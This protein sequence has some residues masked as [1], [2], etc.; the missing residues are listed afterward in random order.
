MTTWRLIFLMLVGAC[1]A[2][3]GT[4]WAESGAL[5]GLP[6]LNTT[7]VNGKTIPSYSSQSGLRLTVDTTWVGSRG[8]R[9][10]QVTLSSAKPATAD[11]QITVRFHAGIW[12]N[13]YRSI[14]ME[15]DLEMLTGASDVSATLLV[16]QY[17]NWDGYGWE[18]WIDGKEDEQLAFKNLG[19]SSSNGNSGQYAALVLQSE[20]VGVNRIER[21][22]SFLE[23]LPLKV[24]QLPDS[25]SQLPK[26]WI[27]YTNFDVVVATPNDL[28]QWSQVVPKQFAEMLRWVRAGGN[29]WVLDVGKGYEQLPQVESILGLKL[30]GSSLEQ[31]GWQFLPLHSQPRQGADMLVLLEGHGKIEPK[32]SISPTQ[33]IDFKSLE[34]AADSR[35]WF[36]ARAHGMGT[37][38]AFQK[39]FDKPS[40]KEDPANPSNSA[41]Q[42]VEFSMLSERLNW[43]WRHGNDPAYGNRNFNDLLI[44]DIG[45]APVFGF[46]L[47]IT[48]FVLAIGPVNY[49]LLKRRGRLPLML[50]TVPVAAVAATLLLFSYGI[51]TEGFSVCV[52]AR[53]ITLLDQ[54]NG[55]ATCWARLSYYAG[56]APSKGLKMPDDTVVYPIH[57]TGRRPAQYAWEQREVEWGEQQNMIR[58]WLASRT[59][60]QYLTITARPT[61]QQLVFEPKDDGLLVTNRLGVEV[62]MLVVQDHAGKFYMGGTL[63]TDDFARLEPTDMM[64]AMAR[65]RVLNTENIPEFPAGFAAPGIGGEA[66]RSSQL[67]EEHAFSTS[68]LEAQ[69]NAVVSPLVEDWGNGTYI[70]ITTTG[71]SLALGLEEVVES[72]SFHMV[73]GNWLPAA[74]TKEK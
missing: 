12:K 65:L 54:T 30:S 48:L 4:A 2:L 55:E 27:G 74:A 57:P 44:P 33:K 15:Q 42:A 29:L 58:G 73:H 36:V 52:R 60:T 61:V 20:T 10:V 68:L 3:D 67:G 14:T 66:W 24:S 25:I 56:I 13:K 70:A 1:L 38:T 18:V 47:L 69:M 31:R 6:M 34:F 28:E 17:G 62:R 23:V 64:A 35:S 63:E 59:P 9:P 53:S 45:A 37:V 5:T 71:L 49:W 51:L 21:L 50:V 19:F 8:Y 7:T 46:Q 43:S 32:L 22:K 11:V 26:K 72:D 16:P 41:M 40:S 39:F